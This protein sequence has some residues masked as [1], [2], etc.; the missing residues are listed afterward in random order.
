M[1][2]ARLISIIHSYV[3]PDKEYGHLNDDEL[4][5]QVLEMVDLSDIDNADVEVTPCDCNDGEEAE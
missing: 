1:A 2:D 5:D 4:V 3:L